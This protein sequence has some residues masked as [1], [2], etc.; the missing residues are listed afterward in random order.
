L[1]ISHAA[2]IERMSYCLRCSVYRLDECF[3]S[4]CVAYVCLELA[5][6]FGIAGIF[7]DMLFPED[8]A[9]ENENEEE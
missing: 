9:K 1:R 8:Q 5:R 3:R 6:I 2:L 7:I 4:E